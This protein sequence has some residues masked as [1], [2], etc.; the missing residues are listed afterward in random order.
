MEYRSSR[1]L[2][3]R[4]SRVI[5]VRM[6]DGDDILRRVREAS[7]EMGVRTA[8]FTAIGAVSEITIAVYSPEKGAYQPIR[9][10]GFHEITSCI[11]NVTTLVDD[12]GGGV[13]VFVHAHATV[14]DHEGHVYGGH[15]LEGSSVWG[16]GEL[17]LF[18]T[19]RTI[20]RLRREIEEGGYSPWQI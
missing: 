15:L 4:V 5:A 16:L 6:N 8:F 2:E 10:K 12:E 1:P 19:D 11:G 18:E 9:K 3:S 20:T 7:E 13:G 14:A 17:S